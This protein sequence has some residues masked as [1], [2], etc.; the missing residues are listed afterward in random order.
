MDDALRQLEKYRPTKEEALEAIRARI[1]GE[2]D[3]PALCK[4]GA[5]SFKDE[6]F[7]NIIKTVL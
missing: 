7:L 4:F 2:W 6:D 3:N 1:H 5:M